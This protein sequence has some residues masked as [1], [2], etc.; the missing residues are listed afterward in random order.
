MH[1][2][3]VYRNFKLKTSGSLTLRV[4]YLWSPLFA[5][6]M[7]VLGKV[8]SVGVFLRKPNPYIQR[9]TQNSK[10]TT[11]IS[12]RLGQRTRVGSNPAP[13]AYQLWEHDLIT[14]GGSPDYWNPVFQ[15]HINM[16][17][18]HYLMLKTTKHMTILIIK[19]FYYYYHFF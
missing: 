19:F 16:W 13:S 15:E 3:F 9:V 10:K 11:E 6:E 8:N 7:C 14:V 12:E 1:R 17:N 2:K 4:C 18:I 5:Q